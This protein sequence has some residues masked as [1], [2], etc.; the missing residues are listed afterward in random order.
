MTLSAS[1]LL[2]NKHMQATHTS[3]HKQT[4]TQPQHNF[5]QSE[6]K[7]TPII[8]PLPPPHCPPTLPSCAF[9]LRRNNRDNTIETPQQRQAATQS[10]HC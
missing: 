7:V 2:H 8:S 6:I 9:K 10:V 3:T 1:S 4:V 5:N